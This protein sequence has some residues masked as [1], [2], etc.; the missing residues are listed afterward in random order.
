MSVKE[1]N[2]LSLPEIT[3]KQILQMIKSEELEPGMRIPTEV[4]LSEQFNVGRSTIREAVRALVS[5]NVLE[6]RQGAGT[7]ISNKGGIPNDPLG[8]NLLDQ[9][10]AL[11][12]DMLDFRI[13][14]EP[15]SAALAASHASEEQ[16][17][18]IFKACLAAETL[19]KQGQP[20]LD[21]D[22]YFHETIAIA[23]GNTIIHKIVQ[24][25]HASIQK[26]IIVTEDSLKWDTITYHRQITEAIKKHD[27]LGAKTSMLLHLTLLRQL[28][29]HKTKGCL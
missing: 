1:K 3:E 17:K 22:S 20:Y 26:N 19:I 10:L 16:I 25:I 4:E 27:I 9:D 15:E 18:Q 24:I 21:E 28:I 7:Y 2:N 23:S 14:I 29:T 12:L 8:L 6:I 13:I 5:H 11:A